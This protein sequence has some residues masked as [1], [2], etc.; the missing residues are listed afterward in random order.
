ML[1]F[2]QICSMSFLKNFTNTSY[3]YNDGIIK[4]SKAGTLIHKDNLN[5]KEVAEHLLS[6]KPLDSFHQEITKYQ[7]EAI[8]GLIDSI[9]K[10]F[11][12]PIDFRV[13]L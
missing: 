10:F 4:D 11:P 6:Y 8:P 3:L 7:R 12:G 1:F 2:T 13:I 5:K 9:E